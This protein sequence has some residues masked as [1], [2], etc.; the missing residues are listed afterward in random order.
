M[1]TL[2]INKMDVWYVDYIGEG[3]EILDE[4]GN[5]TGETELK[6]TKPKKVKLNLYSTTSEVKNEIFGINNNI[7]IVCSTND[8]ILNKQSLLF[9]EEPMEDIDYLAEY[10]LRVSAIQRSINHITYGFRGRD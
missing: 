3:D 5:Y 10:D 4:D 1:R 9:Y 7:D 6:F 2:N 8:L